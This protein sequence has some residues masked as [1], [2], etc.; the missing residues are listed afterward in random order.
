MLLKPPKTAI[1]V[2][3]LIEEFQSI[4]GVFCCSIL[5]FVILFFTWRKKKPRLIAG[6]PFVGIDDRQYTKENA[7]RRFVSNASEIL[8]EG[9]KMVS[10]S[11]PRTRLLTTNL[12]IN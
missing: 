3:K 2:F 9:Y 1:S 10:E 8:E 6:V 11:Q 7:A 4:T 12:V 5:A